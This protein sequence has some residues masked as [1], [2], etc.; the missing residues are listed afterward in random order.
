MGLY[1]ITIQKDSAWEVMMELGKLD[2]FHFLDLNR[3]EQIFSR[4]FANMIRRCDEAER[5]IRY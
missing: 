3:R 4:T 5:I 1:T 2:A